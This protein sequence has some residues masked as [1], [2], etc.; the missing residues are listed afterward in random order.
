MARYGRSIRVEA[1][2]AQV[3]ATLVDVETWPVWASQ[4]KRLERLDAG[5]LAVGSRVRVKP[6]GMPSSVWQVTGYEDGRSFTWT[7]SS[8]PGLHLTGGHVVTPVGGAATAEFWLE[9]SGPIG[10]LLTPI[11]RR[12]IFS[13]NTKSATEGLKS[14]I[15]EPNS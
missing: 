15:E 13:R 1:P 12:T 5:P 10:R 8:G 7:S 11:L 14:H 3:W 4:F 9:A 6:R 2:A